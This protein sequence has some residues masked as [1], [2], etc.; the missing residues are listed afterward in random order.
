MQE[1]TVALVFNWLAAT[2]QQLRSAALLQ[3]GAR[4]GQAAG[5]SDDGIDRAIAAALGMP[6]GALSL[7]PC[8]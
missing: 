2:A 6:H 1:E 7:L 4:D 3:S 8:M 5:G